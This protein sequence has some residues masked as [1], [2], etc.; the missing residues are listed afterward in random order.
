VVVDREAGGLRLR[1]S[2]EPLRRRLVEIAASGR[3]V[4]AGDAG[5]S[6][7]EVVGWRDVGEEVE[8]LLV[9]E[10]G[11]R[12]D[13]PRGIDD[14]RRLVVRLRALDEPRDALVRQLATPRI[15]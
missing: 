4:V 11:A 14:E 5:L 6:P 9:A 10:V 13:E 2:C 7:A 8:A 3:A 1:R 15:S 12:L